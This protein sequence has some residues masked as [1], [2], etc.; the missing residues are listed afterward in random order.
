MNQVYN[1]IVFSFQELLLSQ[2]NRAVLSMELKCEC[3]CRF[4]FLSKFQ[5]CY[6]KRSP[7]LYPEKIKQN[8]KWRYRC[9]H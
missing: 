6:G 2:F 9:N 4:L 5:N 8:T 3:F 7:R 1:D